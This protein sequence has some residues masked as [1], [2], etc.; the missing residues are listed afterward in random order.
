MTSQGLILNADDFGLTPDTNKAIWKLAGMG[1][2]SSTSVMANMPHAEEVRAMADAVPSVG[3]GVHLTLTTGKP[4]CPPAEVPTLVD[5]T[6]AFHSL[7]TLV[8]RTFRGKVGFGE[9]RKELE[10]QVGRTR[11][12]LGERL[13]HWDS[14][15]GVHRFEPFASICMS[16]CGKYRV[17]GMRS[18]RHYFIVSQHPMRVERPSLRT[19]RTFPWRRVMNETYYR[20]LSWRASRRFKLPTGL[21]ALTDGSTLDALRKVAHDKLPEGTWEIACHPAMSKIGLSKSEMI[22]ARVEE[23]ELLA[24]EDFFS[25]VRSGRLR[26]IRFTDLS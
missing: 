12:W 15:E 19:C 22:Q 14:H 7:S 4:V 8:K 24:S 11:S 16:A 18:H 13:D 17:Q 25:A 3:I 6:G 1:T 9:I 26:L 2:L 23:Y 20:L 21:L 10:A 5:E